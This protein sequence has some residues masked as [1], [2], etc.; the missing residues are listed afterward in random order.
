[1]EQSTYNF[2]LLYNPIS[3]G[4]IGLQID[5]ILFWARS[6]FATKKEEE[7]REVRLISRNQEH[8]SVESSIKFK[9]K[10]IQMTSKGI[11]IFKQKCLIVAIAIVKRIRGITTNTRQIIRTIQTP[12]K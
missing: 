1:M 9:K 10:I 12:K 7:I 5:N 3:L 11:S 8:P 6:Q 2:Y 4:I